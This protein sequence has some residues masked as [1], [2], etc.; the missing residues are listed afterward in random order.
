MTPNRSKVKAEFDRLNSIE[1][2]SKRFWSQWSLYGYAGKVHHIVQMAVENRITARKADELIEFAVRWQ[3][4]L[5]YDMP[6]P[7][8]AP[9]K[10]YLAG[11]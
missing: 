4:A 1:F 11:T 8:P 6:E 9:W 5:E 2:G 7:P 10:E 3:G